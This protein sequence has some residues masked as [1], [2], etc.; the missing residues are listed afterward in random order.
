MSGRVE[1][2]WIK[3]AKRG[4]MD[5]VSRARAVTGQGL[6]GNADQGGARQVTFIEREVFDGLREELSPDVDPV[7][8]RANVLLSGVRLAH[9]RDR[10]LRMGDIRIRIR[11]E[12]RPCERMNESVSGLREALDPDWRGGAF[13]EVLDDGEIAVGDEVR[14]EQ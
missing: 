10:V 11:G 12:T 6:D 14:W 5:S 3:R 7:Q 13:G 1:A 9:T 4:V 8:R 2:I